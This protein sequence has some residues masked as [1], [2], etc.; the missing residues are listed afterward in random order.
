MTAGTKLS[1]AAGRVSLWF[2]GVHSH[3]DL[4][5]KRQAGNYNLV[6]FDGKQIG[7]LGL[8]C[9]WGNNHYYFLGEAGLGK[10]KW[11]GKFA[12]DSGQSG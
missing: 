10:Y 8:D 2:S 4:P 6:L 5:L 9:Q 1:Y 11:I 7:N 12:R 3:Y